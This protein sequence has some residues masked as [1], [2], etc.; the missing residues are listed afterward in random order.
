MEGI[1]L[2]AGK[3]SVYLIST[4]RPVWYPNSLLLSKRC[5]RVFMHVILCVCMCA[6]VRAGMCVCANVCQ[7]QT[8]SEFMVINHLM[9]T[10]LLAITR[11][12]IIASFKCAC[13]LMWAHTR[14]CVRWMGLTKQLRAPWSAGN[15]VRM[16]VEAIVKTTCSQRWSNLIYFEV[17][18]MN[19]NLHSV[20]FAK[21]RCWSPIF[22][23]RNKYINK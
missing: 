21:W 9:R 20:S 5:G 17:T 18:S 2:H 1:L 12:C 22:G 19:E 13:V 23:K 3:L 11:F 6:C 16:K 14:R 8:A 10:V 4:F 15:G 7:R